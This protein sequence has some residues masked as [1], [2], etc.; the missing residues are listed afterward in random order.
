MERERTRAE[1]TDREF[2]TVIFEVAKSKNFG[3]L[4]RYLSYILSQR[5]RCYDGIGWI[6]K[7][8]LGVILPDTSSEGA[9]KLADDV[10][11]AIIPKSIHPQYSIYTYPSHWINGN[12]GN[13]GDNADNGG[14]PRGRDNDSSQ[15]PKAKNAKDSESFLKEMNSLLSNQMPLWKRVM[16]IFIGIFVFVILSPVLLLIAIYIKIVS[17]GPVFFG[18]ERVGYMGD[19]FTCWKFRTMKVNASISEHKHYFTDL[20]NNGSPMKKLDSDDPR[21]IPF[22]KFM[23]KTGLDELP[24]LINVIR[25]EMSLIGPRPCIP[26]EALRYQNWQHKR[27]DAVPGLTGLWQVNGKNRTTFNEMM[28][29]DI[30]YARKKSIWLD[31][32]IILKTI[33]AIYTQLTEKKEEIQKTT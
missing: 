14:T 32:K 17:P 26:Y 24:Q 10:C 25:G 27:F 29:F 16:D 5:V 7:H 31:L 6:D 20:M 28:R 33:P 18:Q 8:R 12:N 11:K 23:R 22:G 15:H 1:R 13:N 9:R 30:K 4:I 3:T 2:S 19:A 21:I